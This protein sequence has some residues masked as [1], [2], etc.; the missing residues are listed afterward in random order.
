MPAAKE[1]KKILGEVLAPSGIVL[2]IDFGLMDLW[3]HDKPP[4]L[5]PG[6]LDPAALESANNGVDFK[7]EGPD[8]IEAGR[9]FQRQPHPLFLYDTPRHSIDELKDDFER[10]ITKTAYRAALV[11]LPSR[12]PPRKRVDDALAHSKDAAAEVFL[13]GI[14]AIVLSGLPKQ[15]AL[16]VEA[17]TMGE[18]EFSEHWRDISLLI[19]PDLQITESRIIG[20]VAVDMARLMFCDLEAAAEWKHQDS[21]DGLADFVFWGR[22]AVRLA[23]KFKA[24]L[25]EGNI[26]GYVDKPLEEAAEIGMQVQ[27]HLEHHHLVAACD[28][29]PHSDHW[30]MLKALSEQETESGVIDLSDS[31]CCGFMTSWGDGFFPVHLDL[32]SN[33]ELVRLR[34]E[35]G[36]PETIRGMRMVNKYV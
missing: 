28:F 16:K 34:I 30:R 19:N 18:G 8:A 32:A 33:G 29:R 26:Y 5:N 2:L 24:P 31:R 25:I 20:H 14:H 13:H 6:I 9:K 27:K 35:L 3:T 21:I 36:T 12:V 7:I 1:S 23:N 11:D 4:L 10:F 17:C 22:D 15:K